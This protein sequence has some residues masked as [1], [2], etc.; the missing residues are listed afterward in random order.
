MSRIVGL[1]QSERRRKACHMEET[2]V[3]KEEQRES[4]E[5]V[6]GEDRQEID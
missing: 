3:I 1:G 4:T 2:A 5:L 6:S